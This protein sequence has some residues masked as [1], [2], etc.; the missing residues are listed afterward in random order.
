MTALDVSVLCRGCDAKIRF[1]ERQ[2]PGCARSLDADELDALE[3][4]WHAADPAAA[5]DAAGV[6]YGRA[7]IVVVAVLALIE[8][9][10]WWALADD[11]SAALRALAVAVLFAILLV[12]SYRW[13]LSSTG[14][15][16]FSYLVLWV[17]QLA[18]NPFAGLSALRALIFFGLLAGFIAELHARGARP[19]RR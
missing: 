1:G 7:A 18:S 6:H 5:R 9:G 14:L 12:A 17:R 3:A 2:C 19:R 8:A 11:A 13:P 16:T 10:V 15:A 4:R